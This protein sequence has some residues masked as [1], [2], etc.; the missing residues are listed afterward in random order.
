[1]THRRNAIDTNSRACLTELWLNAA[2]D[3]GVEKNDVTTA[4]EVDKNVESEIIE[5][6]VEMNGEVGHETVADS[7][8][9]IGTQFTF[10]ISLLQ[11]TGIP[12]DY[13]DVYCQ[14]RSAS[15]GVATSRLLLP[16]DQF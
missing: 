8:L 2:V 7:H 5:S 12:S 11:A 6:K 1:L 3:N 9:S 13:E 4:P 15:C 14:F 16:E 10:R